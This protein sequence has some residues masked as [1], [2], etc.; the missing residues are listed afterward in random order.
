[1]SMWTFYWPSFA[2]LTVINESTGGEGDAVPK[3][4]SK[5][6]YRIIDES[7]KIIGQKARIVGRIWL[8]ITNLA[9]GRCMNALIDFLPAWIGLIEVLAL[10]A[11]CLGM[12]VQAVIGS[13][14]SSRSLSPPWTVT[15][16]TQ[17]ITM[18]GRTLNRSS[19][20]G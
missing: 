20:I 10:H 17:A 4:K 14:G 9:P 5:S 7:S 13:R 1:M 12:S 6:S 2:P 3:L 8:R 18:C 19:K 11:F 16:K 15:D